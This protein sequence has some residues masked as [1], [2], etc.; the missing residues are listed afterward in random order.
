MAAGS[1]AGRL[2]RAAEAG[3]IGVAQ[4]IV[5]RLHD[6][7]GTAEVTATPGRGTEVELR[8]RGD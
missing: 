2:A 5:G 3:R 4:S 6:A 7:G 1:A 8:V